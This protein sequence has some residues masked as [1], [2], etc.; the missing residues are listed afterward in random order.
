MTLTR[1][2]PH[3]ADDR[4]P[5]QQGLKLGSGTE[6]GTQLVV[7]AMVAVRV[8]S[9]AAVTTKCVP[10]RFFIPLTPRDKYSRC[11]PRTHRL[12]LKCGRPGVSRSSSI[13]AA[14]PPDPTDGRDRDSDGGYERRDWG[15]RRRLSS[16]AGHSAVTPQHHDGS[17]HPLTCTIARVCRLFRRHAVTL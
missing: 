14:A 3:P 11:E 12:G 15:P 9:L 1:S 10:F 2:G 5:R 17:I 7:F 6:T 4:D 13:I 8:H 16:S